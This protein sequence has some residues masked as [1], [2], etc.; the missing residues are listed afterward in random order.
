MFY[1]TSLKHRW[2]DTDR[3]KGCLLGEKSVTMTL[4]SPHE[5][6]W[7]RTWASVVRGRR[8][9]ARAMTLLHWSVQ[10]TG[11]VYFFMP[12]YEWAGIAIL[13][14]LHAIINQNYLQFKDKVMKH[15]S[16][17]GRRNHGRPLKRLLDTW[18]QNGSTSGPTPWQIYDDDK[19]DSL[20]KPLRGLVM[21]HR[22][23]DSLQKFS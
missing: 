16:P 17:T 8:L 7:D 22:Y 4:R 18:D 15:Y 21:G 11:T 6:Q 9:T 23:Q 12:S 5:L 3:G 19:E 13:R 2:N 14:A 10:C 20:Y 1:V